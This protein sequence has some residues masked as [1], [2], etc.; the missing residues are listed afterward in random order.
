MPLSVVY[1][2]EL[3]ALWLPSEVD[4][5]DQDRQATGVMGHHACEDVSGPLVVGFPSL[6]ASPG[7]SS[8]VGGYC[9]GLRRVSRLASIAHAGNGKHLDRLLKALISFEYVVRGRL[10]DIWVGTR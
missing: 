7:W 5:F 9:F 1:K 10:Q 2:K 8:S 6:C 4:E 3:Q